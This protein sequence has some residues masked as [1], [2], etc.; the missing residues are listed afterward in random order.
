[1]KEKP[2][3]SV[4]MSVYNGASDLDIT[5]DSVLSQ[6]GVK[7]EFIVV[8]DGST[9]KTGE[10]LEGYARRDGRVRVIHQENT[11]LTHALIR[12]CA[13]AS[14]EFIARQDV[15]DVSLAGRLALQVNVFNN[16]SRVVMTSCG[17]RFVGPDNEVLYEVR[18]VGD[19]LNDGLRRVDFRHVR[20]VSSHPSVM[21]RRESYENVGGY[22]AQFVVAQDLDLWMRFAE[23]GLCWGTPEILCEVRL[24]KNSISSA[25]K[26]EQNLSE[27]TIVRCAAARR[28]GRDDSALVAKWT[29]RRKWILLFWRWVPKAYHEAKFYYFIGSVLRHR[30]PKQAQLY[31]RRAVTAWFPYPRAWYRILRTASQK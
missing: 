6:D 15:G 24:S 22:R 25:R 8:N 28:S 27:K 20:G 29:Q 30:Q 14:G 18:H 2:N 7:L 26:F 19:E 21:F 23:I 4:V 9:D 11:G 13:A 16:N 1:M 31:F 5:M 12:G 3:V 17:T 10:I